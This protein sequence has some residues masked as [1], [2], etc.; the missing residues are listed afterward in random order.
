MPAQITFGTYPRHELCHDEEA[1]LSVSWMK[2]IANTQVGDN[3]LVS[4]CAQ[5]AVL[6]LKTLDCL[7]QNEA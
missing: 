7:C 6:L 4:Q 5:H 1:L 3:P 2:L